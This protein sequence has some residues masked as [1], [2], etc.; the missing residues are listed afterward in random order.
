MSYSAAAARW[1]NHLK[2]AAVSPIESAGDASSVAPPEVLLLLQFD[3]GSRGNPGPGGSGS[4]AFQLLPPAP[5]SPPSYSLNDTP[6]RK[7]EL[8]RSYSYLGDSVTNN[9]AEYTGLLGCMTHLKAILRQVEGASVRVRIE[10]D[11]QLVIRQLTGEYKVKNA[12]LRE[13]YDKV[14]SDVSSM[15]RRP[16]P[17]VRFEYSHVPRALNSEADALSNEAMDLRC[18][19]SSQTASVLLE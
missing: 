1:K 12:P 3:G 18:S 16:S 8:W 2:E 10:G 11:S 6:Y 13:I 17:A 9:V 14:M 15:S 7:R 5:A 4:V 19:R